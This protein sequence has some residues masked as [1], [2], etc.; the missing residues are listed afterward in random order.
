MCRILPV[1]NRRPLDGSRRFQMSSALRTFLRF[2][3]RL[4]KHALLLKPASTQH[5]GSPPASATL[6]DSAN[7]MQ[8]HVAPEPAPAQHIGSP[9]ASATLRDSA[10]WMQRH[11]APEPAPAQ[12]IGS[13]PA[14][15]TLRDPAN[16]MQRHVAPVARCIIFWSVISSP[17]SSPCIRPW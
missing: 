14:S 12:H 17:E 16:W 2:T 3:P 4:G 7:W 15:A 9:P 10:N 11:V 13:P 1:V 8:R 6:R 5:I